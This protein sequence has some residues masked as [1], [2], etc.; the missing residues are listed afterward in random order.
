MDDAFNFLF[1]S[2]ACSKLNISHGII[3]DINFKN[4]NKNSCHI[5]L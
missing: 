5:N 1:A 2:S 3:N 4:E